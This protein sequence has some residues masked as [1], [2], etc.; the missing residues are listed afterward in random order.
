MLYIIFYFKIFGPDPLTDFKPFALLTFDN[1]DAFL[2][3]DKPDPPN[4]LIS[5]Q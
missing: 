1:P 3:F 4:F 5:F 2:T